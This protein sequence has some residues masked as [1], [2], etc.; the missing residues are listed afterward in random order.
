MRPWPRSCGPRRG[1]TAAANVRRP[2]T[3]EQVERASA[4]R[5]PAD[6]A[7]RVHRG[8]QDLA[9][10]AQVAG[11]PFHRAALVA[12]PQALDELVV[13]L[14]LVDPDQEEVAADRRP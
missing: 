11:E 1:C 6:G 2:G 9:H 5:N 8:L 4:L 13:S 3:S 12:L 10:P 14:R 7:V